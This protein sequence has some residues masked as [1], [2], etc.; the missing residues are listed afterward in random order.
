ME[1]YFGYS[2]PR[3]FAVCQRGYCLRWRWIQ[4][5]NSI[6]WGHA[7]RF[8]GAAKRWQKAS[9][10]RVGRHL[11]NKMKDKYF[12]WDSRWIANHPS[13]IGIGVGLGAGAR[14]AR[15][16]YTPA[17]PFNYFAKLNQR[18]QQVLAHHAR[19][20]QPHSVRLSHPDRPGITAMIWI[21][22]Q[23]GQT[24]TGQVTGI[25]LPSI[26]SI[27]FTKTKFTRRPSSF[28]VSIGKRWEFIGG[29][30]APHT[31]KQ[32]QKQTQQIKTNN[33][34]HKDGHK[35][36]FMRVRASGQMRFGKIR[37]KFL[38]E[39]SEIVRIDPNETIA[40]GFLRN[41]SMFLPMFRRW[42]FRLWI[43]VAKWQNVNKHS[44]DDHVVLFT[45]KTDRVQQVLVRD[46]NTDDVQY[47]TK[48]RSW[49]G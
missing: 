36:Q 15:N 27:N 49:I 41:S 23:D 16:R 28:H 4:F 12:S 8:V 9:K 34:L 7:I 5:V 39:T 45:I 29:D 22:D 40:S 30:D 32:N 20:R 42:S 37:H 21:Y 17:N 38:V 10:T 25:Q 18:T 19:P 26:A 14:L 24:I 3:I 43:A 1:Q 35:R 13:G 31:E 47:T 2:H 48:Q 6:A 11:R 44:F 46:N 33:R